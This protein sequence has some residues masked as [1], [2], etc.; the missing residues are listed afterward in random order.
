[1]YHKTIH[2]PLT[3][4]PLGLALTLDPDLW[5]EDCDTEMRWFPTRPEPEPDCTWAALFG[6]DND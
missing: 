5:E 1:M 3:R 4:E 6:L 2:D